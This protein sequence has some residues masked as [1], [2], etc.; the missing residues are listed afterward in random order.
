MRAPAQVVVP[1]LHLGGDLIRKIREELLPCE[2]PLGAV[3]PDGNA[4]AALQ[5][6]A[7][8]SCYLVGAIGIAHG[9]HG[10]GQLAVLQDLDLALDAADIRGVDAGT[11]EREGED[12]EDGGKPRV[13]AQGCADPGRGLSLF[14]QHHPESGVRVQG[15]DGPLVAFLFC[16]DKHLLVDGSSVSP[17]RRWRRARRARSRRFFTALWDRCRIFAISAT[18]YPS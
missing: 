12:P 4:A 5:D 14:L 1:V 7:G 17:A 3:C 2:G 9:Q 18:G 16:H 13:K 11:G 6:F 15:R 8:G 10:I